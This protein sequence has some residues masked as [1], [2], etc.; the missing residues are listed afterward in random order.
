MKRFINFNKGLQ[1]P[2][3]TNIK[4]IWGGGGGCRERFGL[5]GLKQTIF[6]ACLLLFQLQAFVSKDKDTRPNIL[7]ITP[8]RLGIDQ[9]KQYGGLSHYT[10]NIDFLADN[11]MTFFY[12]LGRTDIMSATR[13]IL[14]GVG[15]VVVGTDSAGYNGTDRDTFFLARRMVEAGYNTCYAG[16]WPFRNKHTVENT[17]HDPNHIVGDIIYEPSASPVREGFENYHSIWALNKNQNSWTNT[18]WHYEPETPFYWDAKTFKK[19]KFRFSSNE[20]YMPQRNAD[21]IK[22]FIDWNQSKKKPKPFYIWWHMIYMYHIRNDW[23]DKVPNHGKHRGNYSHISNTEGIDSKMYYANLRYMDVLIGQV[24]DKLREYKLMENTV[25]IF[26]GLSG[27]PYGVKGIYNGEEV[28]GLNKI[29]YHAR[30]TGRIKGVGHEV[31]KERNIRMPLI[32]HWPRYIKQ[33]TVN[34]HPVDSRDFLVTLAKLS[35]VKGINRRTSQKYYDDS[36]SFVPLLKGHINK[37]TR[38]KY[39]YYFYQPMFVYTQTCWAELIWS[40][41]PEYK[42]YSDGRFYRIKEDPDEKK[43]ATRLSPVEKVIKKQ[44]SKI[45]K[46]RPNMRPN[47]KWNTGDCEE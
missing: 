5:F 25:I 28:E 21:F 11:G 3:Y 34:S 6:I 13:S 26:H 22:K 27:T 23:Y 10:P 2:N 42:L 43:Q 18:W 33:G 17:W 4:K 32:V 35:K 40:Q 38:R 19:S 9:L 46:S 24:L 20:K 16:R 8:D 39:F 7:F 1:D 30:S 44:L 12:C 47:K 41:S 31:Y 29:V 45:I 37:G 15:D 14:S 36:Y